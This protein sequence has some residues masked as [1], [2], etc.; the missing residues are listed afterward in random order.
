MHCTIHPFPDAPQSLPRPS[1]FYILDEDGEIQSQRLPW[2][3]HCSSAVHALRYSTR[4]I[5]SRRRATPFTL[6]QRTTSIAPLLGHHL[7]LGTEKTRSKVKGFF[8][9][10]SSDK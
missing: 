6:F 1:S 3:S 5:A 8:C 7:H 4:I 10:I 9:T 2:K